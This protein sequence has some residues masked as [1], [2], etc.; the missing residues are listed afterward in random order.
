MSNFIRLRYI[1]RDCGKTQPSFPLLYKKDV[2]FPKYEVYFNTDTV[3]LI[4]D[5]IKEEVTLKQPYSNSVAY[6]EFDMFIIKTVSNNWYYC[7][8]D[9]YNKFIQEDNGL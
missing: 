3:E 4:S 2:L 1:Y 8:P 7:A 6:G 5:I 9:Q